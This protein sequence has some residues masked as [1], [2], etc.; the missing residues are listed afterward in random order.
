MIFTPFEGIEYAAAMP[1]QTKP[2]TEAVFNHIANSEDIYTGLAFFNP[3]EES[4]EITVIAKRGDGTEAGTRVLNLG[5]GERIS[6]TLKDPDMLPETASLLNG[7]ISIIS[8]QP[9]I[10]QQLYGGTDLQF[11]AAVPPTTGYGSMFE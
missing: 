7:F 5:P 10:C 11:L 2:V 9:L 4:A 6:R 8:T 3:G 1:L